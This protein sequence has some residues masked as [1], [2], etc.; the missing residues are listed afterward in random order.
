[1]HSSLLI[2]LVI[3]PAAWVVTAA[4]NNGKC[5]NVDQIQDGGHLPCDP[6]AEVSFCCAFG[7]ICLSNGLCEPGSNL[8]Q[9]ITP[10]FTSLCT[11]YS[12]SSPSTCPEIR[13]NNKTRQV[14]CYDVVPVSWKGNT[15]L[16]FSLS[17]SDL[18]HSLS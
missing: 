4:S 14:D 5:Y 15:N 16:L 9:Y 7:N 13:N 12:W 3:F 8:S 1:M 6:E 10:Y 2:S 18:R 11:D 17:M